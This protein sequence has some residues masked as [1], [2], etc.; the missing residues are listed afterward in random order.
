MMI[1]A[2]TAFALM[3]LPVALRLTQPKPQRVPVVVRRR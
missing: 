1:A 3:A 2:L